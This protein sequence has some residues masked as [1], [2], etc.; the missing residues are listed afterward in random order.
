MINASDS[1]HREREVIR[2]ARGELAEISGTWKWPVV[3]HSEVGTAAIIYSSFNKQSKFRP[4]LHPREPQWIYPGC[5]ISLPGNPLHSHP[6]RRPRRSNL[7]KSI[8]F[9]RS[10]IRDNWFVCFNSTTRFDN[11]PS[12]IKRIHGVANYR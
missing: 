4:S 5:T 6:L 12:Y 1:S 10:P 3:L 11:S 9:I 8:S 2:S 7:S